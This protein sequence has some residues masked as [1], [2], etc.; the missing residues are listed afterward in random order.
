M[1]KKET[2]TLSIFQRPVWVSL[3]ALTAAISWGWAYPLIKMGMEEY[4][5]TADMTGSKMLFAGIRFFIS[6]IIILAIARSSHREFG[7]KKKAVQ[8]NVWFL[9]LYALLNTTLHYAFFYFGLSHNAGARSAILN[10]MSVFTVVIL[11][12]IFFKSDR[13]TW[14][15]ALGCII[16]FLGILA[17]NLGGKESGSFT[18]LGD[19]MIIL[20]ALCG[21]SASL[22]TR[23]LSKR[24]DVFVGTGYSL[25]IGGALLVIPALLMGGY[26]PVISLWGITILLL[27]IAISTISFALYNKLLSCNPVAILR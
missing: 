12:C 27:L 8:E 16:G 25:S 2:N 22:L 7:F 21:A 24:V 15:K 26:L 11:A 6:G 23:G 9:L 5:I 20:N 14:Q 3:F 17:L 10:S 1:E 18:F 13:M 19:G 4:Q